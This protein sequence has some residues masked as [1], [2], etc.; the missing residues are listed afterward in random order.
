MVRKFYQSA[1]LSVFSTTDSHF[2]KLYF[3]IFFFLIFPARFFAQTEIGIGL[4]EIHFDDKTVLEF[5][6]KP[7]FSKPVKRIEFFNDETIKSW[8]IRNLEKQQ[9]WLNPESLWLDYHSFVFRTVARQKNWYQVIVNNQTGKNYWLRKQKVV[10]F[11]TWERFLTGVFGVKR[12]TAEKIRRTP[13][14]NSREIKYQV[15]G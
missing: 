9:K 13:S 10:Q 11:K 2:M 8:N 14:V 1:C 5:Y 7:I 3:F 15:S 6:E 4:V 12:R